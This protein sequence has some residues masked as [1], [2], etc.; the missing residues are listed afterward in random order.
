MGFKGDRCVP[1][2]IQG[3]V[4]KEEE[5][6]LDG[7]LTVFAT[8]NFLCVTH[9]LSDWTRVWTQVVVTPDSMIF[10]SSPRDF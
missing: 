7:R 9:L 3:F 4:G 2:Q 8:S 10:L 6:I 1:E 5:K